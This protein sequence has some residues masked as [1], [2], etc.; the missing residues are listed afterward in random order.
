M[1]QNKDGS[2]QGCWGKANRERDRTTDPDNTGKLF[3]YTEK[4]RA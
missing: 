3:F 1:S 2:R 4:Q